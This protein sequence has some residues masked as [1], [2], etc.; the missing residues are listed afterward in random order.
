MLDI[1]DKNVSRWEVSLDKNYS[2]GEISFL[3]DFHLME[4]KNY[5]INP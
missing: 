3:M 1:N 5:K 2:C 4:S